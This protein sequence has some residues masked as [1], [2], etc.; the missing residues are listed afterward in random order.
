MF[1]PVTGFQCHSVPV[2]SGVNSGIAKFC[3]RSEILAG[4]FN[5]NGTGIHRNDWNPAGICRASL[6][7]PVHSVLYQK[8]M[9]EK[10]K[11]MN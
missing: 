6:R 5:W 11:P 10:Q 8:D 2:H 4:K 3:G 7:P 1:I 9:F